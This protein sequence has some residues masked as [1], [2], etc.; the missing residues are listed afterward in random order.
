MLVLSRKRGQSIELNEMEVV[1]RVVSIKGSRVQLGIEAPAEV[2]IRRSEKQGESESR[3]PPSTSS[4]MERIQDEL[5][6]VETEL[7]S[8]AEFANTNDRSTA[9]EVASDSIR[10]LE[11]VRRSLRLQSRHRPPSDHAQPIGDLVKVRA[12]VLEQLRHKQP[13]HQTACVRQAPPGYAVV[14]PP[15]RACSIA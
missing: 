8:L 12:D 9:R 13:D 11:G 10:R 14:A 4:E 1:V 6:R 7:A 15:S 3:L 5:A 2:T